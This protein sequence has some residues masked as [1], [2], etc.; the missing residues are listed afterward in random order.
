[1][2]AS[3]LELPKARRY[4]RASFLRG[5]VSG[6]SHASRR[7]GNARRLW[8]YQSPN[9]YKRQPI[10]LYLLDGEVWQGRMDMAGI[11]DRLYSDG[12][13]PPIIA[14]FI[15]N[16][17]H[18][19]R[20]EELVPN[21]A[22][23]D[24]FVNELIPLVAQK[25]GE[26][27]VPAR[28][29]IAGAS[30]GGLAAAYIAH[31]YPMHVGNVISMSGSFWWHPKNSPRQN[32]IARL[33][34]SDNAPTLRWHISAGRYE[35]ARNAAEDGIL[36]TSRALADVLRQRGHHVVWREYNGGHDYA[37]WENALP[38]GLLALFGQDGLR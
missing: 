36:D 23:A 38:D 14:L 6:F 17:D 21:A 30:Y 7:L 12:R 25:T 37:L 26:A 29:V 5:K 18:S 13:L 3:L 31:R 19:T 2:D 35:T 16:P 28:S 24:M 15:A 1:M 11:L 8:F 22:F 33:Y 32:Y 9:P 4:P 10:W 34:A 27:P 20:A